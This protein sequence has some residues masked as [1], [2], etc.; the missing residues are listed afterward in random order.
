VSHI[1][2]T[3]DVIVVAAGRGQRFGG[4]APKQYANLGGKPVVRWALDAFT[5][6]PNIR[7][8]QPVIHPDDHAT[9]AAGA[10]GLKVNSPVHGGTTRQ[11]SVLRGLEA[12][13]K[14][15]PDWVLIHDGA[16][17]SITPE[18]IDRVLAG[19]QS[20]IGVIPALP[21]AD[22]LK[23]IDESAT[24]VETVARANLV[25]AQ[26][27]QGFH[28][29]K[30]LTAHR[31]AKDQE[32]TDDAAVLEKAGYNVATVMGSESNFKIT[33]QDDLI[34]ME[35]SL[36]ETRIGQ[37][38]DVHRFTDGDH[39]ILCGVKVPHTH[40]L[41]GHSDADVALHAATDAILGAFGAGD[42]GVHFP[43]SNP[44]YKN[45]PSDKFLAHAMALLR[46]RGGALTHLDITIIC[47]RPKVSPHRDAMVASIARIAEV[48]P[49]RISVKATTTEGLGF[50][51]RGEGIAAQATATVRIPSF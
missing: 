31:A 44:A 32:L 50:T 20:G 24:I 1:G 34:R 18:L 46:Q 41:L 28:F 19:L 36:F 10:T 4:P 14:D 45:A 26:T 43:P 39:V 35:H 11:E 40:K 29:S 38:F 25:R 42:I 22:T 30:I 15:A 5:R 8:I 23:R 16:R 21:V 33:T 12:L 7:R 9:F 27:P 3:C 49:S 6:H 47:E 37:G 17:P 2:H 48:E 51:G 13:A